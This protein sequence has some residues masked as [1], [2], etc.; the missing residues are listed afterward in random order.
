MLG[1]QL[2]V[3][4]VNCGHSSLGDFHHG[5]RHPAG[6]QGVGMV[7]A[8]ELALGRFHGLSASVRLNSED[9]IGIVVSDADMG[10]RDPT[11][12]RGAK[13]ERLSGLLQ[14]RHFLGMRD[15]IRQRHVVEAIEH[16]FE[17]HRV[18]VE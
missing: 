2:G 18:A 13:A 3:G 17:H 9:Q 16:V 12:R 5:G 10:G 15:A 8:G 14:H 6:R 7:V 4:V 11:L 1:L